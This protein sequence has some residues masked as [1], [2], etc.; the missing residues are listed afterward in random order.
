MATAKLSPDTIAASTNLTGAVTDIDEDPA[1]P[2]ANWLTATVATAAT[3]LRI[4]F[5]T[6]TFTPSGA[7]SFQLWLRKTTGTPTPTADISL[8]QGGT[9]RSLLLN[10]TAI[11]STTGQLVAANWNSSDLSGTLD[12]SDVE[13]RILSTPGTS[14]TTGTLP[15]YAAAGTLL[16]SSLVT[17]TDSVLV[18]PAHAVGDL[19]I[20]LV[21][22]RSTDNDGLLTTVNGTG[23]TTGWTLQNN[24]GSMYGGATSAR[25]GFG[26]KIA[27]STSEVCSFSTTGGE[28]SSR[29]HARV[30]KFTA[31]DGFA[32]TPIQN[33]AAGTVGTLSAGQDM[34]MPTVAAGGAAGAL[35]LCLYGVSVTSTQ[36]APTGATGGTWT[37]PV[38]EDLPGPEATT[39]IFIADDADAGGIS[40]GTSAS[41]ATTGVWTNISMRLV[42]ANALTNVNTIETG[43][44]GWDY[45]YD[46]IRT[47]QAGTVA[48][49]GNAPAVTLSVTVVLTPA[50]G[51]GIAGG[52]SP[53][54]Q[55]MLAVGAGAGIAAATA[56]SSVSQGIR[57]H[58]TALLASANLTGAFSDISEDPDVPNAS[59][60]TAISATEATDVRISFEAPV[61]TPVGA[62]SF[63]LWVRKTA[64][65]PDPLVTVS[66]YQ[67][68]TLRAALL[69][70]VPITSTTGQILTASWDA[71]QLIPPL[72]GSDVECRITATPGSV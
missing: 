3:D 37:E 30:Y 50:A 38:A 47:P 57:L 11:T 53:A 46:D 39:G 44:I 65:A 61:L 16:N 43:A 21:F 35:A 31:A 32:A 27:T 2:D 36:A 45:R 24:G 67:S 29:L 71:N 55:T 54:L 1:S 18:S 4:T 64:G 33:I 34:T 66:L 40:G 22:C 58:P 9:L 10:D 25:I 72:D 28:N 59:W 19:L 70:D 56:S 13:C 69:T 62:Q 6:P 14:S 23:G 52:N 12:G 49:S 60:L 41:G 48:A 15:A 17:R 20:A 51:A 5:P 63:R 42:P 7:Q 8:Y 26:W 68:G